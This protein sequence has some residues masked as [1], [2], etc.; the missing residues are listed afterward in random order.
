MIVGILEDIETQAKTVAE[1][2]K[3]AGYETIIRNDG[4]SFIELIRSENVEILLLDWD[5][6]GKNGIEVMKWV[7]QTLGNSI[8]II[9]TTHHES[10]EDI[11]YGLDNGADDYLIKPV[12]QRELIA[13]VAAHARKYYPESQKDATIEV[14][15]Y[16]LV[17]ASRTV[18]MTEVNGVDAPSVVLPAREF[19]L[20]TQ[21]FSS[22][23]RIVPK[24]LLIRQIWGAV[25][26]KYDASLATYISKI[27][28]ALALRSKNGLV[29]STVYNYGY[30]LERV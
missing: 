24:D 13:R 19:D 1:W 25:D 26:R 30:R 11:V 5:V 27:R 4:D 2:L 16:V 18:Q 17:P 28:N 9:F 3:K 22:V 7:R 14:G 29:I 21:L 8:P 6:P 23:G 20:A 15:K 10:E 12:R